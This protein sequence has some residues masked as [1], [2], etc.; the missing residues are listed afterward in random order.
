MPSNNLKT[1]T[2]F[3]N[4]LP[5][6]PN[7]ESAKC[8]LLSKRDNSLTRF[9]KYLADQNGPSP[10]YSLQSLLELEK[11]YFSHTPKAKLFGLIKPEPSNFTSDIAFYWGQ[12][13]AQ[14]IPDSEWV[15]EPFPFLDGRY[16]IGIRKGLCTIMLN[17]F[18]KTLHNPKNKKHDSLWRTY[19][20]YF[21]PGSKITISF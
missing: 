5:A 8:T 10:D 15:V 11:W 14:N 7:L 6:F 12:V 4:D 1:A 17:S 20:H 3:G 9:S 21:V 19:H 2:V 18:Y 16:E 13:V